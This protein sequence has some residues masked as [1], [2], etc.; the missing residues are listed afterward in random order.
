[1]MIGMPNAI[2]KYIPL[3]KNDRRVSKGLTGL[4]I[5]MV[6]SFI[7]CPAERLKVYLMT[8]NVI[9]SDQSL[10]KRFQADSQG[11]LIRELYRGYIP[12]FTRQAVAWITF[13]VADA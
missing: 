8:N 4:S 12:L 5:G 10:F 13:L 11:G 9:K 2:E 1:M 3:A 6:E 7:L